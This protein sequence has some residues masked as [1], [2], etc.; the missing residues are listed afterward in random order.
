MENAAVMKNEAED[1][2]KWKNMKHSVTHWDW[3]L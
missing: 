1:D 3:G 2:L